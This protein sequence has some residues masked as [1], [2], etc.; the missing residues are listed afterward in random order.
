M[1]RTRNT[2]LSPR[3]PAKILAIT[4]LGEV[5]LLLSEFTS[6]LQFFNVLCENSVV[7]KVHLKIPDPSSQNQFRFQIEKAP[8]A[9]GVPARDTMP[10]GHMIS[11]AEKHSISTYQLVPFKFTTAR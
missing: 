5:H 11:V 8:C 1:M 2:I 3:V 4:P 7:P 6:T 10:C 9:C